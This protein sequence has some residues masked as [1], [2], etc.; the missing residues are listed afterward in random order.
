[1]NFEAGGKLQPFT[2]PSDQPQPPFALIVNLAASQVGRLLLDVV[3]E[4][5]RRLQ[6]GL[7]FLHH[8][9]HLGV[10]DD[11]V[12]LGHVVALSVQVFQLERP[13]PQVRFT[14]CVQQL[15]FCSPVMLS[16]SEPSAPLAQLLDQWPKEELIMAA[17]CLL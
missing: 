6:I 1:M 13:Q 8:P 10:A 3:H 4:I 17:A 14:Q 9:I 11:V 16:R 12:H 7:G 15:A 2:D 5:R